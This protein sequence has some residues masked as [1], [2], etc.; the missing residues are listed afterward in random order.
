M[1]MRSLWSP[2]FTTA[3]GGIGNWAV[4]LCQRH[5]YT[6]GRQDKGRGR[7]SIRGCHANSSGLWYRGLR[8]ELNTY[9]HTHTHIHTYTHTHIHTYTHT[10]IHTYTHTHTHTH[11]THTRARAQDATKS[12]INID[13]CTSVH[14]VIKRILFFL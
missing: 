11:H 13:G 2:I 8:R 9:T 12:L 14:S 3:A 4:A 6:Q 7:G 5:W 10:H 1:S